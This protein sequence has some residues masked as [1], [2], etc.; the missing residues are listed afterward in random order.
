MYVLVA[1][2]P[3][4]GMT[5]FVRADGHPFDSTEEAEQAFMLDERIGSDFWE[6]VP[7]EKVER[8]EQKKLE[9]VVSEVLNALGEYGIEG[10]D[11]LGSPTVRE[12]AQKIAAKCTSDDPTN[13]QGDT[14]PVHE[15]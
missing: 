4:D 13:H 1:G 2:T 7:V 5:I 8:T 6:I 15:Q 3:W 14:C 11:D 9:V 12:I 10:L